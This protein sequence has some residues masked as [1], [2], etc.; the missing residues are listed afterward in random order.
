MFESME[1]RSAERFKSAVDRSFMLVFVLFSAFVTA[2]DFAFGAANMKN[3]IMNNLPHDWLSSI[4]QL[5]MLVCISAAYPLM[6]APMVAPI[7]RMVANKDLWGAVTSVFIVVVV[8][9]TGILLTGLG[10]VNIYNGV[11]SV[12]T[13]GSVAP[14]VVGLYAFERRGASHKFRMYGLIVFGVVIGGLCSVYTDNYVS[15]MACIVPLGP[16]PPADLYDCIQ[17]W[18][19]TQ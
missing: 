5:G 1:H 18:C 15:E 7:K 2:A 8:L 6:V 16:G 14:A 9:L 17:L 11:V 13:C 12:V 19:I 3:N 10:K 4:A